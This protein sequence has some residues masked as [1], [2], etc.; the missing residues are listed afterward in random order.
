MGLFDRHQQPAVDRREALLS[1]PA[2]VPGVTLE[3]GD[4][5]RITAVVTSRRPDGFWARFMSRTM[6]RRVRLDEIGTYVIRQIDGIRTVK[7][8][9]AAFASQYRVNR[10]EAELCMA[11][12]LKSLAQRNI[13]AIGIR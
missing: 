3:E 12:F 4:D 6:T 8:L 7:E 5:G 13:I 11:D 9:V 1:I 10:R 2:L